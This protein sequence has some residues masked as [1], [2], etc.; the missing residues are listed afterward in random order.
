MNFETT[1]QI[2]PK[3]GRAYF[4]A[5]F[6]AFWLLIG[7]SGFSAL[8]TQEEVGYWHIAYV[9]F[10]LVAAWELWRN[11][12]RILSVDKYSLWI[13]PD[14]IRYPAA[15]LL[16]SKASTLSLPWSEVNE[17]TSL[18]QWGKTLI[19]FLRGAGTDSSGTA[20]PR[21]MNERHRLPE[22]QNAVLLDASRFAISHEDLL[23]ALHA[24]HR[25][26]NARAS[27]NQ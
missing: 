5:A 27:S 3:L 19:R 17:I 12:V 2:R 15:G 8:V 6:Y 20:K 9:L 13:G 21:A 14:G 16:S 24:Y 1:L 18:A 7:F 4:G 11:V 10:I 26:W 22:G 25:K 23:Q